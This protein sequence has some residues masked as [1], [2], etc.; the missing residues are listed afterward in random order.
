MAKKAINTADPTPIEEEREHLASS[1]RTKG[2]TQNAQSDD[3]DD[4]V[5][6]SVDNTIAE[7]LQFDKEGKVL[8]FE[9]RDRFLALPEEV[10]RK[11]G[12]AN[13]VNYAVTQQNHQRFVRLQAGSEGERIE[14]ND[15]LDSKA[16]HDLMQIP[17]DSREWHYFWALPRDVR[18]LKGQGYK[19]VWVSEED[20]SEV[21]HGAPKSRW[22]TLR[23]EHGET[24]ESN[25]E[26]YALKVKMELYRNHLNAVAAKSREML[27]TKQDEQREI[28]SKIHPSLKVLTGDRLEEG[29]W[30]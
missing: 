11:M 16:I 10:V 7:V 6:I 13:R 19:E 29:N 27:R 3:I 9:H 26:Y 21:E 8:Q 25:V 30:S 5:F 20:G 12:K 28:L 14:I 4:A 1:S 15:P 22:L 24:K 18:K 17:A 23:N 2:V